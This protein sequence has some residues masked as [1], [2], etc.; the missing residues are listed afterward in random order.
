[1][2]Y[3]IVNNN[4]PFV[5]R[6]NGTIELPI[7]P[8]K[9]FLPNSSGVFGR[10]I[11]GWKLG[12]IWTL[13]SGA[14][15]TITAQNNLYNNG[16]PDVVDAGLLK[17]LL[18]DTGLR[19]KTPA[20][21]QLQ[22]SF[23]DP[24]KWTKVPDPQCAGVTSL[25]NLN[26]AFRCSLTALAKIVPSSTPGSTPLNDG[27]GNSYLIVLQNPKP[28]TQGNLGQNVLRGLAPW[29]FDANLGKSF[30]ITETKRFSVRFDAQN[31]LNHPQ[32]SAPSLDI[33][34]SFLRWGSIANG[35]AAAKTGGRVFQ[36]QLRLDF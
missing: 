7:G 2:D 8:G 25:Q 4:H 27:S 30:K 9:T 5:L 24:N 12:G 22:G 10:A 15:S 13:S 11:E 3:T 28:G 34:S 6:T 19:W 16:V 14:Y 1:M 23:F 32:A 20:G 17:E 36:G 21:S 26:G 29:R 31:V 35:F 18:G 33:N